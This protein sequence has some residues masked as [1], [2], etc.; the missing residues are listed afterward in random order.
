MRNLTQIEDMKWWVTFFVALASTL[1]AAAAYNIAHRIEVRD[2]KPILY[3]PDDAWAF[4]LRE[5]NRLPYTSTAT[6][7]SMP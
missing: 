1:V 2:V 7:R 4:E 6:C 3:I 5:P